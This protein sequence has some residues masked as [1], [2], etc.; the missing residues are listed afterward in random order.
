MLSLAEHIPGSLRKREGVRLI[1]QKHNAFLRRLQGNP[2]MGRILLLGLLPVIGHHRQ[3]HRIHHIALRVGKS[4]NP[5]GFP[6]P[7]LRQFSKNLHA[8]HPHAPG[9]SHRFEYVV[10]FLTIQQR[11]S[12]NIR[13]HRLTERQKSTSAKIPV[14]HVQKSVRIIDIEGNLCRPLCVEHRLVL[15]SHRFSPSILKIFSSQIHRNTFPV[16]EKRPLYYL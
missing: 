4:L 1:F 7:V 12:R 16:N 13:I 10:Q 2:F 3:L 11:F 9:Q 5:Q 14:Q 15:V 8:Q 6:L